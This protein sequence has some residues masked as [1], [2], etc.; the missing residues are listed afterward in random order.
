[1]RRRLALIV[2]AVTGMVTIAFLVPL[3]AVVKV[4]ASDRALNV[5][6]QE[7]RSLAGV[8]SAVSSTADIASV[9]DQL[10]AQ[11][12]GR[13]ASVFLP[14]GQELGASL[15][16]PAAELALARQGRAFTAASGG[17]TRVWATVHLGTGAVVVGVVGVPA[18]LLESGVLR[19]W[20]VLGLV[21]ALIVC[22]GVLLADRL[23]RSMVRSIEALGDVTRRLR[24]GELAARVEPTGPVEVVSVGQAVNQLADRIIELVDGEREAAAD[25]SHSLRTPLAALQLE[26]DTLSRQADR[27]RMGRA[28]RSMTEAIDEVIVQ[29]RR[30]RP[31]ATPAGSDLVRAVVDR[32]AFWSLL[33][34]EQGRDSTTHVP[35]GPLLV[36]VTA[37]ELARAIDA[38]VANVFAHTPEGTPFRVEVTAVG[39]DRASL[40]IEDDGPGFPAGRKPR[41]GESGGGSTGLGLDIVARTAE[42]GGGE[43]RVGASARGGARVEIRFWRAERISAPSPVQAA[44]AQPVPVQAELPAAPPSGPLPPPG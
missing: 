21:G 19:A 10:N 17:Q 12:D 42:R 6:D 18:R 11:G 20:I 32:L 31:E 23:G 37:T 36:K 8:L 2:L 44:P 28:V 26:A 16:V 9:L 43:L 30:P 35:D 29:V 4:V 41:R 34:G 5:A 39:A 24:G 27:Q 3:G 22:I 1:M 38:L 14:D 40:V 33:A 15:G 7:S 13:Q 25:L